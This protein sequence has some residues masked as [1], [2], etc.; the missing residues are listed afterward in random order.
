MS[1]FDDIV[2]KEKEKSFYISRIPKK[3]KEEIIR[4]AG[5]EFEED[6]GMAIH[7]IWCKFKEMIKY[8]EMQDIKLNYII[9]ILENQNQKSEVEKKEEKPS[10]KMMDGRSVKGGQHG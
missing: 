1:D 8:E 9:Q 7:F 4:F 10:I 2:L 5:E 6:Y 3:T